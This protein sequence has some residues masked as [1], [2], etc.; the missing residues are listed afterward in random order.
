MK[1]YSQ[2]NV[3][4]SAKF[5]K[6]IGESDVY[7]FAGIVGDFNPAHVNSVKS[8]KSKFGGRIAHGM[9]TASFI[10]TVLGMHLPGPG[11]IYLAQNLNFVGAVYIGDT[12]IAK[13]T[14]IEKMEKGRVR[15]KTECYNSD[16][17]TVVIGEATVIAPKDEV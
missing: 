8:G 15:L 4:D 14:V 9:L 7:M 10:S 17:E 5:A 12:V 3:G 13:V 16:G 6:T 11:T 2:I 1:T